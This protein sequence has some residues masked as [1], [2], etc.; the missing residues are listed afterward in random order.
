MLDS[1]KEIYENEDKLKNL[2]GILKDSRKLS[3]E[4]I[5]EAFSESFEVAKLDT[6]KVLFYSRDIKEGLGEKRSFRIIL[7]YLGENYPKIIKK[8]AHLIA[9]YGR[10]DDFYSLFDTQ[11]EENVMK[12]FRRQLEKDLE[13]KNPSLLAKWLKSENTASKESRDLARKTIKGMGFT[14]KQYRKILSYLRRKINIVETNITFKNYNKINY[15]KVPSTAISKYKKLFLEKDEENY[16]NF[17]NRV[18]KNKF[19]IVKMNYKTVEDVLISKRYGL[20]EINLN[21]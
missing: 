5:I 8:N 15:A 12:L 19:N 21:N 20:V 7:K 13:K 16:L 17:K 18:R 6:M 9:Y 4:A 2:F 3:E 1:I 14:P 10:W 11:L